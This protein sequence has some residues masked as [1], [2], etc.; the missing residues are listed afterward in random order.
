[1]SSAGPTL[2]DTGFTA[3]ASDPMSRDR[4][5][6]LA[7]CLDLD[8][9]RFGGGALPPLWHWAYFTPQVRTSGLGADGHPRRRPDM[10]AFPQRMWVGGRLRVARPLDLDVGATRTS[11]IRSA[12]MK[13]GAAGAFWL[14]T[15]DH[16]ISQHGQARITEEQDLVFRGATALTPPGP[17]V[18]EAPEAEWVD[19]LV[20]DS[21][22][23][24]R[25]S[26]VTDNAHRIHYDY[27]YATEVEGY[28]DLVV[29][30]PLTALL[31]AELAHSCTGIDARTVSFRARAP[32]FA[33][34][35][36]W[37]TAHADADGTVH[38]TAVRADHT[39]AVTL[40]LS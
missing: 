16:T 38:T 14:V 18:D 15:V 20:P 8:P 6:Q 40:Q 23:L 21:V 35:R 10:D 11:R 22:L 26:A 36:L 39:E 37:L 7:A 32:L 2:D 27:P 9:A 31:L 19:M 3:D 33:N 28:P 34:H 30:G 13:D 25:F 17:D 12:A 24:F 29:H 1:V 5:R 4:A